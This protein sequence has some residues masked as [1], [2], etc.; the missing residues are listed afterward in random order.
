MSEPK[1]RILQPVIM[2]DTN[3]ITAVSCIG[4]FGVQRQN[5]QQYARCTW[6]LRV[7]QP[8]WEIGSSC[9]IIIPCLGGE[10][11]LTTTK[12]W[13]LVFVNCGENVM[14]RHSL[15]ALPCS[16]I[17]SCSLKTRGNRNATCTWRTLY[18]WQKLSE[19]DA[20]SRMLLRC[21]PGTIEGYHIISTFDDCIYLS[22][23]RNKNQ[24][25]SRL[26]PPFHIVHPPV[27]F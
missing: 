22:L 6:P 5:L 1:T 27:E 2:M 24:D 15:L 12:P 4:G 25:C 3:D 9:G 14:A 16:I 8:A 13:L 19:T 26:P 21:P 20:T 23:L 7:F 11:Y 10:K 18:R 17:Q